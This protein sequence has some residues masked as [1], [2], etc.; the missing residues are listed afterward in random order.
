MGSIGRIDGI[1]ESHL[2]LLRRA[3]VRT[4]ET[5]LERGSTRAGRRDLAKI[6]GLGERRVTDWVKRADLLRV[7]GVSTS[8]SNLLEAVGVTTVRDLRRR[9][10]SKLH[11]SL[12]EVG[13]DRRRKV[14]T[15]P[16]TLAVVERWVA[17]ARELPI[18]LKRW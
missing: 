12:V 17:D 9:D 3:G 13:K 5:L 1:S 18:V 4:T 8:Y 15:R 11:R 2:V 16:P 7:Q 6:V 10:P 14:S